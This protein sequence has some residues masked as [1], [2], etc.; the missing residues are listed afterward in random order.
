MLTKTERIYEKV[1]ATSHLVMF[2]Q[3]DPDTFMVTSELVILPE[4]Y[5]DMGSPKTITVTI[6]PGD[7]LNQED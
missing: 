4:D 3:Q 6:E 5:E 2:A 7:R 1:A